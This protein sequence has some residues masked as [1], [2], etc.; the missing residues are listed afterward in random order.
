MNRFEGIFKPAAAVVLAAAC[1]KGTGPVQPPP[2]PPQA[3]NAVVS[4][5]TPSGN[6][7]ALLVTL[8]GPDLAMIQPA[9]SHYVLYSRMASGQEAR[10][11]VI[12]DLKPGPLLT[13]KFSAPQ[14][15]SAYS[16]VIQQVATRG[17]SILDGTSGYE[18]SVSAP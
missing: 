15:L 14:Q 11:I 16:G 18:L 12:G 9:D 13:L 5:A 3:T 2:P 7:G 8:S 17:D 4:L 10:V 1:D 6:D